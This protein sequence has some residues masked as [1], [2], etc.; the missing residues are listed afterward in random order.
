M[1]KQGSHRNEHHDAIKK[2]PPVTEEQNE[3]MSKEVP[4]YLEGEDDCERKFKF[5]EKIFA[6]SNSVIII[7]LEPICSLGYHLS[8]ERVAQERT[9]DERRGKP[10]DEWCVIQ[11]KREDTQAYQ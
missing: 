3:A 10:A 1:K 6:Y 11:L 8:L 5:V 9:Q 2:V 4:G 7:Q